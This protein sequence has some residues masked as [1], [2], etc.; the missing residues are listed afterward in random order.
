MPSA[1]RM[2]SK[3]DEEGRS[4]SCWNEKETRRA[5]A[6]HVA[7]EKQRDEEGRSPSCWNEKKTRRANALHVANEK[8]RRA[9][10]LHVAYT[11]LCSAGYLL[12]TKTC[13]NGVL[14]VQGSSSAGGGSTRRDVVVVRRV[15]MWWWFDAS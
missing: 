8:T 2:K 6:L 13:P 4:P 5:N 11:F 3:R 12:N 1:L 15:V 9:D 10:P 14:D 7:N